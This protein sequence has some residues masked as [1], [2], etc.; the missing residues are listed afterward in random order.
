MINYN[1]ILYIYLKNHL[2]FFLYNIK[3]YDKQYNKTN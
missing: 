2:F 3:L 1:Y